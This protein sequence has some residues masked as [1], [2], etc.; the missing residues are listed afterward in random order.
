MSDGIE[1]IPQKSKIKGDKNTSEKRKKWVKIRIIWLI[2]SNKKKNWVKGGGPHLAKL[3]H[4]VQIPD[5]TVC[6][7][8]ALTSF[9]KGINLSLLHPIIRF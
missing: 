1:R 5:E 2:V 7:H 6:I 9:W 8:F 3:A 4:C